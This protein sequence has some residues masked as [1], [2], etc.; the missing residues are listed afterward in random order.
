MYVCKNIC[1]IINI[2]VISILLLFCLLFG[3]LGRWEGRTEAVVKSDTSCLLVSMTCSLA[4]VRDNDLTN[5]EY[6]KKINH[7]CFFSSSRY[8]L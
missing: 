7:K 1:I 4:A 8:L 3:T 5:K 2:T 6:Y